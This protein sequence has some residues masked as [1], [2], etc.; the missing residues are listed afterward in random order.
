MNLQIMIGCHAF[1]GNHDNFRNPENIA[2]R[3]PQNLF[4]FVQQRAQREGLL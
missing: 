4:H 1:R 3:S 2:S